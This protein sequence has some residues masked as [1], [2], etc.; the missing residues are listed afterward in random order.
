MTTNNHDLVSRRDVL[1][2]GVAGAAGLCLGPVLGGSA[3]AAARPAKAK[4]VIQIWMWGGPAHLDTFDP[5]PEAG[6]DYT[7]PL[8]KPIPTNVDGIRIGQLLPELAKQADKYSI[9]RGMT[10]GVNAHETASYL[11]QTGRQP[12][13]GTVYPS[14]GAVV[15]FFKGYQAGYKGLIPPYIV[16]TQPQGRFSEAGFLGTRYKP[17]ATGGDPKQQRFAVEGVVAQGISDQRQHAR[18]KLLGELDALRQTVH[19]DP[20]LEQLDRA[21][22]EAYDLIL[23][24]AGKVFDLSSEKDALRDKYGRS[25]FGQSCLV[26]RRLVEK[27]VRYVTINYKGW[28]THKQHFQAMRRML[29][30]MDR[31]MATLLQD[32][33][34][35]GLLDS[36]IVWWGGEFGRTPKVQW[37]PPWN[38][39]RG[40]YGRV[41]SSVVA[42]GG[43]KGGHVVG[44][45][46]AKGEWVKERPIY[47]WDLIGSMYELLGID[48]E[49]TLPHPQGRAVRLTLAAGDGVESGGRL[50]EIM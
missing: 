17:F 29:P 48:P 23:G 22:K 2:A 25:T 44:A 19:G 49:G 24:D 18:R 39:G 45:S 34:D 14:V 26:A 6:P 9:L 31:G 16:L 32:L 38:G 43:F 30:E 13:D 46:D 15:S 28:D 8:D 1:K 5:K 42:G 35:H 11:V 3:R 33:G 47:P 50:K 12:G 4:A 41:F 36:T 37:E 40:H 7:G 21:E 27:G 20:A 10:H